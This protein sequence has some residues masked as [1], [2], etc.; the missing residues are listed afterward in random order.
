MNQEKNVRVA[1][2][3][4]SARLRESLAEML[5]S[6]PGYELVA[7]FA[8]AETALQ[9]IPALCPD[10]VLMDIGL[11]RMSGIECVRALKAQLPQMPV[12]M[13]T[14][15]DEGPFLFNSLKAGANG[16]LLK[17]TVADKLLESI[18]EAREGGVPLTR[19]M[20]AK[21]AEYFQQLGTVAAE[22][23]SLTRRERESL[24]LLAQGFLYKEIAD[25]L[26][27]SLDT[28]RE[29]V[30]NIYAKLH[31]SSRTEAVVKFLGH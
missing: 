7:S 21:I 19:Q 28:V 20:A 9:Q 14:V 23:A 17:R 31:V 5:A 4:D 24:E 22:V 12:L 27:I 6:A 30:R 10:V 1:L 13:L 26:G 18:R 16:Y 15:Y 8:D 29:Y 2:V 25:R 3:E 11:P